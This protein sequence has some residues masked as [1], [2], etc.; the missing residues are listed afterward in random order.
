MHDAVRE[1]I[2]G[3]SSRRGSAPVSRLSKGGLP[4]VDGRIAPASTTDYWRYM[5]TCSTSSRILSCAK[6]SFRRARMITPWSPRVPGPRRRPRNDS[7]YEGPVGGEIPDEIVESRAGDVLRRPRPERRDRRLLLR[8]S[9]QRRF[10]LP[11][12]RMTQ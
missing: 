7:T 12:I 11:P 9:T 4:S 10:H 5:A 3:E 2:A 6:R 8:V 1:A